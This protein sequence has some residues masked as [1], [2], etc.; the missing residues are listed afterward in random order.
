M[1]K[2][3]AILYILHTLP[4]CWERTHWQWVCL[5][6]SATAKL[7]SSSIQSLF[8][9]LGSIELLE[10]VPY[11]CSIWRKWASV[12]SKHSCHWRCCSPCSEPDPRQIVGWTPEGRPGGLRN[13][14]HCQTFSGW[15]ILSGTHSYQTTS[16][17]IPGPSW[18]PAGKSTTALRWSP[19]KS[20]ETRGCSV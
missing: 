18:R 19:T 5:K 14:S 4:S 6:I 10:L 9:K 17:T 3:R 12:T 20:A 11:C 1:G 16:F 13:L 15:I 2:T 8:A 7:C